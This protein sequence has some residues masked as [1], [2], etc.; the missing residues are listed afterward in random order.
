MALGLEPVLGVGEAHQRI[1]AE[2]HFALGAL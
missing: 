2:D 1:L